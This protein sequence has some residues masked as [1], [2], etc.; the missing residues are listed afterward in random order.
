MYQV[1]CKSI[2]CDNWVIGQFRYYCFSSLDFSISTFSIADCDWKCYLHRYPELVEAFGSQD[3]KSAKK[4]W[5]NFGKQEGRDCTCG[6]YI[7]PNRAKNSKRF[8]SI[9]NVYS[10]EMHISFKLLWLFMNSKQNQVESVTLVLYGGN[11]HLTFAKMDTALVGFKSI[12]YIS[13]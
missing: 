2:R 3:V 12:L 11:V 1:N 9:E 6:K 7:F 5:T 10:Q 13:T 8:S 4:H